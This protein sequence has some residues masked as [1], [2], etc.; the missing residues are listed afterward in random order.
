MHLNCVIKWVFLVSFFPG[1]GRWLVLSDSIAKY[2]T[3]NDNTDVR[4]FRGDTVSRLTDRIA[5][6][7]VDVRGY[8][9]ILIHV[10]TNDVGNLFSKGEHRTMTIF[11]IM[12]SFHSLRDTIRRRNS[13]AMLL[14]SSILP[15][16]NRYKLFRPYIQGLNFA[17]EKF[18]AK[19]RGA[20]VFIPSYNCFL[21]NGEPR[22]SLFSDSDG[23]HLKGAGVVK[24]QGCFQQAFSSGY[25][26]VR[27]LCKQTRDMAAIKY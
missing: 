9:R 13:S 22:H 1:K 17:L 24:L 5:F 21:L 15:R 2:V 12:D 11:R 3:I 23:L 27:V 10:G 14:F 20:N 16:R 26:R 19:S 4:A 6:G 18:C 8:S 25:L 7:E